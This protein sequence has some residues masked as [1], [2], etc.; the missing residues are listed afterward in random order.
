MQMLDHV[1][2]LE[3]ANFVSGP[4]AGRLLADFGA[5]VIKVEKPGEGDPMRSW[6]GG[7]YSPWFVA[8][9]AGK[10]SMT[11]RLG[12]EAASDIITRLLP[13]IDILIENFRPGVAAA[14][15]LEYERL[16]AIA[17]AL[18]YCSISGA[19]S[20]GPYATQPFFDTIGQSM[21]GLLSQLMSPLDPQPLGPAL[22]DTIS[23]VF[24]ALGIVAALHARMRTGEG[25]RIEA[26]IVGSCLAMLG[27]PLSVMLNAGEVPDAASRRQ[28]AQI[29]AFHCGDGQLVALH[30]SSP[31]KNWAAL[32]RAI[33][34]LDLET[35]PRFATR[36]DRIRNYDDLRAELAAVFA[37]RPR[38]E[39]LKAL[40]IERVP[41]APVNGL[42]E[43][44]TD[45]QVRELGVLRSADHPVHGTVRWIGNPVRLA[46]RPPRQMRPPPT[47]GEHTD[48]ILGELGYNRTQIE[49]L[50][51]SGDV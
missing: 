48:A 40:A 24:A 10:R 31:H 33:R 8:H 22:A 11:L 5:D 38:S 35:D 46:S 6:G 28:A 25:Q 41:S 26:S 34:R 14:F 32:L 30:L 43:A 45:P 23:G 37:T 17:P 39:W 13:T 49:A 29:Y 21:S 1:R 20:I 47:L 15:G 36:E 51:S 3:V 2:V 16:R 9:N 12:S 44:L 19:G 50:R 42:P 7:R 18:V 4:W 27:E